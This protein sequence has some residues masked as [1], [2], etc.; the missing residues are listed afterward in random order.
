YQGP[1]GALWPPASAGPLSMTELVGEIRGLQGTWLRAVR[2]E[3]AA[4]VVVAAVCLFF[5]RATPVGKLG[6][7]LTAAGVLFIGCYLYRYARVTP[8]PQGVGFTQ[9]VTFYR[10]ILERHRRRTRNLIWWYLLALAPGPLAL[11]VG[12]GL[13]QRDPVPFL[14]KALAGV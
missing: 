7:W 8:I 4:S 3:I 1:G 10:Q 2:L 12:A 9:T 6:G 5:L 14:I 13:Q 11:I